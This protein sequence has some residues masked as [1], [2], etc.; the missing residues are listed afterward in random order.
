[1]RPRRDH[2][3]GAVAPHRDPPRRRPIP[4][5]PAAP[6]AAGQAAGDIADDG[7]GHDPRIRCPTPPASGSTTACETYHRAEQEP[8][9]ERLVALLRRLRPSLH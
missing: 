5:S 8:L 6:P 2:Q 9:P 1:M 3:A 4:P 7:Q